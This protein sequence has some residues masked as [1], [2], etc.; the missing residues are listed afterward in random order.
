MT[1][2]R[3]KPPPGRRHPSINKSKSSTKQKQEKKT[4]EEEDQPFYVNVEVVP[5]P[6]IKE[7]NSDDE[8]DASKSAGNEPKLISLSV[9]HMT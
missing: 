7:A 2:E 3:P 4:Q 8:D 9:G 5:D 1:K 6:S